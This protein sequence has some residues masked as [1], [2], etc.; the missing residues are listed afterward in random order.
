MRARARPFLGSLAAVIIAPT[1]VGVRHHGLAAHLVEGDLLGRMLERRRD[2]DGG[3]D[4]VRIRGH[5]LQGLH[6]AHGSARHGQQL[7]D[8]E[9]IHQPPLRLHHVADGHHRESKTV[10][11]PG[12]RIDRRGTGASAA[13]AEY[14]RTHD[15]V[16][17]R[18]D[19]LAGADHVVPPARVSCRP[20]G[21]I[22]KRARSPKTRGRRGPR[23]FSSRSAVRRSRRRA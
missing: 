2:R 19:G 4:A 20:D 12:R 10:R 1:P 7:V 18:V 9:M 5:P 22:P 8:P 6:P 17:V 23:C 11:L 15:E 3:A 13:S 16:F 14:V 21:G